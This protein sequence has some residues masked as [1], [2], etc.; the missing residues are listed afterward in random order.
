MSAFL[1]NL[2]DGPW[3]IK[4]A[5]G[6]YLGTDPTQTDPSGNRSLLTVPTRHTAAFFT[7]MQVSSGSATSV[8][9]YVSVASP[10]NLAVNSAG[11]LVLASGGVPAPGDRLR[12]GR[13]GYLRHL[14]ALPAWSRPTRRWPTSPASRSP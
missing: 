3:A 13:R 5:N 9:V 1:D 12:P 2:L 4:C 14:R 10:G 11:S 6:Q 8:P 7:F